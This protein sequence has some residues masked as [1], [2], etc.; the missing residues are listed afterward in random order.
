MTQGIRGILCEA[1]KP[2]FNEW[3][4]I[5]MTILP[6]YRE[7]LRATRFYDPLS[8]DGGA[9]K[10]ISEAKAT[11]YKLRWKLKLAAN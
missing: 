1:I 4:P 9:F 8:H 5:S 6:A 10:E 11:E 3:G 7:Y 2:A